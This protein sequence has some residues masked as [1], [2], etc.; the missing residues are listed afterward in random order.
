MNWHRN[1]LKKSYPLSRKNGHE[2]REYSDGKIESTYLKTYELRS[3][4]NVMMPPSLVTMVNIEPSNM[5]TWTTSGQDWNPLSKSMCKVVTPAL[6]SKQIDMPNMMSYSLK[7][8]LS[9]HGHEWEW[10]LSQIFP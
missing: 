4:I 8:S 5:Y 1:W 9:T 10:T 2:K 7:N 3:S 6:R